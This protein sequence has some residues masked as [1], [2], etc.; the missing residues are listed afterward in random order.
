[1]SATLKLA[2]EPSG[3]DSAEILHKPRL[4][5]DNGS[6]YIANDLAKWLEDQGMDHLRGAPNHPQNPGQDRA[7]A[8]D[9]EDRVLPQNYDRPGDLEISVA[10]FV[11]TAVTDE[12]AGDAARQHERG[13][14]ELAKD[15]IRS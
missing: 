12:R 1:M 10:A 7:L 13:H 6:S 9:R 3:C 2:L 5:S 14:V 15:S 11:G 4:P 8:S